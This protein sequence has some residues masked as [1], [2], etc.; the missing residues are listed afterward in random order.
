[1]TELRPE[2][3]LYFRDQLRAARVSALRDAEGFADI[4]FCIERLGSYLCPKGRNLGQFGPALCELATRSPLAEDIPTS[5]RQYHTPFAT[6]YDLVRQGR[7][8][9]AHAGVAARHLTMNAVHLAMVLEDALE[10]QAAVVGDYMVKDPVHAELWEPLSFIR[11][12]MLGDAFSNLPVRDGVAWKVI[13]DRELARFLCKDSGTTLDGATNEGTTKKSRLALALSDA[14]EHGMQ[15]TPVPCLPAT[16][17]VEE[18][19]NELSKGV[20]LVFDDR[21]PDRLLGLVTP[22]DLL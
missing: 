11:Q 1:M 15:L 9:T 4:F 5:F 6:L 19:V 16:M 10:Q 2:Q 8:D 14:L 3:L 21:E 17:P 20:A 7:N 13:S 18:A 22:A 12:K